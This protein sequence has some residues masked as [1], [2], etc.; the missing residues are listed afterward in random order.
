MNINEQ[1]DI[2]DIPYPPSPPPVITPH[3]SRTLTDLPVDLKNYLYTYVYLWTTDDGSFWM[4]PISIT[5]DNKLYGYQWNRNSWRL[6]EL[7]R[8]QI[9]SLF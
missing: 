5:P 2:I 6:V 7:D 9:D 4:Y 1:P 8:S 3:Y